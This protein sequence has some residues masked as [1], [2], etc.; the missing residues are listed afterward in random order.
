MRRVTRVVQTTVLLIVVLGGCV[1]P[2]RRAGAPSS[3]PAGRGRSAAAADMRTATDRLVQSMVRHPA[4]A[5]GT[6]PI[7]EVNAVENRTRDAVGTKTI[8][9]R[10][11]TALVKTRMV[12]FMPVSAASRAS[13]AR[14]RR[15]VPGRVV[16]PPDPRR[17]ARRGT[18]SYLL[19]GAVDPGGDAHRYLLTLALINLD[20]GGIEWQDTQEVL[21]PAAGS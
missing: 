21:P 13:L 6:R 7:V 8:T 20:T 15:L 4:I 1:A 5:A 12:R 3:A 17:G 10:L 11:R 16:A 19:Y 18:G 9:D 2:Q 14:A